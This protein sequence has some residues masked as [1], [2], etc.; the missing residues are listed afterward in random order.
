MDELDERAAQGEPMS[1]DSPDRERVEMIHIA[2]QLWDLLP[3][4]TIIMRF[5]AAAAMLWLS[6]SRLL[7]TRRPPKNDHQ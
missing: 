1:S 2:R 7:R 3:E 4:A 6:I 5:G